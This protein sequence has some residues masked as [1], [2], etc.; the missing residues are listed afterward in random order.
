MAVSHSRT[1]ALVPLFH[2]IPL[3]LS[4]VL[5]LEE[6]TPSLPPQNHHPMTGKEV[7][8]LDVHLPRPIRGGWGRHGGVRGV[9]D[10]ETMSW[11]WSEVRV[12]STPR[13]LV[14]TAP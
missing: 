6:G 7:E 5:S 2:G 9:G 14:N 3:L 11:E 12:P 13:V 10:R 8:W 1:E 4:P